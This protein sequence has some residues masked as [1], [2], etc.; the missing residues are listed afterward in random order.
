MNLSA[1]FDNSGRVTVLVTGV[2]PPAPTITVAGTGHAVTMSPAHVNTEMAAFGISSAGWSEGA[3]PTPV[4]RA[5][6]A[7][8]PAPLS[9]DAVDL[10]L[11][12]DGEPPRPVT[13][14]RP[15]PDPATDR[16]L[17]RLVE[18]L[19]ASWAGRPAPAPA[20]TPPSTRTVQ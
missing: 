3:Q 4:T 7:E 8:L 6:V 14:R 1:F 5:W 18:E 15:A 16:A 13:V 17:D 10:V 20:P 11:E 12:V 19:R 2:A 9:A